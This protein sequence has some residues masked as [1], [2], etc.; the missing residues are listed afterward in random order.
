MSFDMGPE[1]LVN[2]LI[3]PTTNPPI[4]TWFRRHLPPGRYLP[5]SHWAGDR[6][7]CVGDYNEDYPENVL[8]ADELQRFT[9]KLTKWMMDSDSNEDEDEE[10]DEDNPNLYHYASKKFRRAREI[11]DNDP[12]HQPTVFRNLS[13]LKPFPT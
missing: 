9:T 6:I 12:V 5:R 11:Y 10:W 2:Y 3:I 13:K 7:M 1:Y 8:T 4:E